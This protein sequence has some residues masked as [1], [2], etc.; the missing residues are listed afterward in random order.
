MRCLNFLKKVYSLYLE[1]VIGGF[2][3]EKSYFDT[4]PDFSWFTRLYNLS[5]LLRKGY[6]SHIMGF[7]AY[8]AQTG[9]EHL[10]L[11]FKTIYK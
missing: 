11:R 2:K 1:R 9:N 8:P 3:S 4:Y 7:P 5:L 6:K 10:F